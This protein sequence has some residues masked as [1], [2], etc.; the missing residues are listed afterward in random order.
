METR[1]CV[2]CGEN[3]TWHY[4]GDKRPYCKT[5]YFECKEWLDG[6]SAKVRQFEHAYSDNNDQDSYLSGFTKVCNRMNQFTNLR[7]LP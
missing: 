2:N 6:M 1:Q 4:F 5:C 3:V 7:E